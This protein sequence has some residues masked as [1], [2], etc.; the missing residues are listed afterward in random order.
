MELPRGKIHLDISST[1]GEGPIVLKGRVNTWIR[2]GLKV[3]YLFV[4]F[5]VIAAA[6]LKSQDK[7]GQSD[8]YVKAKIF[9]VD[10]DEDDKYKTKTHKKNLNPKFQEVFAIDIKPEDVEAKRLL[11]EVNFIL[12]FPSYIMNSILSLWGYIN[13]HIHK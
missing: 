2:I 5:L 11:V 12:F 6:G 13:N 9:P 10:E 1:N 7:N 8:T 4:Q 3:S